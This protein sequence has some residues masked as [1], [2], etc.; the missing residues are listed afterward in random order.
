MVQIIAFRKIAHETVRSVRFEL[1]KIS[2]SK[3][4]GVLSSLYLKSEI[5]TEI[6]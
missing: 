5:K 6:N 1:E 3:R 2:M 4:N